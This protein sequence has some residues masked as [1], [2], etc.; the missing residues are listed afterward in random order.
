MQVQDLRVARDGEWHF[1]AGLTK[2]PDLAE[3]VCE[4]GD[5]FAGDFEDRVAELHATRV[6][7]P[8][9]VYMLYPVDSSSISS[10]TS[11]DGEGRMQR[12]IGMVRM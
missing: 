1:H 11:L 6:G 12:V 10:S 3:H 7:R 4:S 9:A 5:A 8:I 2:V